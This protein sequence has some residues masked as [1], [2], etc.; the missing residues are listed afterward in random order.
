M[1]ATQLNGNVTSGE[2]LMTQNTVSRK[3]S[4]R[5]MRHVRATGGESNTSAKCGARSMFA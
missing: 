1:D 5:P 2:T 4:G 3:G